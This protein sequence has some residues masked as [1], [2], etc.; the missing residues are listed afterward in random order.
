MLLAK[1]KTART[2]ITGQAGKGE[3]MDE[4]MNTAELVEKLAK[5]KAEL[6]TLVKV[7]DLL[8]QSKDVEEAKEKVKALLR[9][10]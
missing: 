7:L 6:Q 5:E 1:G 8:E 3:K 9:K 4:E 2:L 10:N